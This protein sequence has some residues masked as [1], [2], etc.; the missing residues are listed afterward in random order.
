[1][2]GGKNQGGFWVAVNILFLDLGGGYTRLYI[3]SNLLNSI[4]KISVF[5]CM[6]HLSFLLM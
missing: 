4:L 3:L 6:L 1:M 5:L 2:F